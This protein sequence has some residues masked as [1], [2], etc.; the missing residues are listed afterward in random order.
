[1]EFRSEITLQFRSDTLTEPDV[2]KVAF[3][4][5]Y[6]TLPDYSQSFLTVFSNID[7]GRKEGKIASWLL[8]LDIYLLPTAPSRCCGVAV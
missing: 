1:M 4:N 6:Y 8:M 3:T 7:L 5:P 2:I